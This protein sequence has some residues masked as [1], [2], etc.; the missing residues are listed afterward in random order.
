MDRQVLLYLR[1]RESG[2]WFAVVVGNIVDG[3]GD[4]LDAKSFDDKP[5]ALRWFETV[6]AQGGETETIYT[7][8]S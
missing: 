4:A 5:A 1:Q 7:Q 6:W 2:D 8:P 3:K